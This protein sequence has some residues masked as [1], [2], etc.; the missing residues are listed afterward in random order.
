MRNTPAAEGVDF[1]KRRLCL[2]RRNDVVDQALHPGL[3]D[4]VRASRK[5]RAGRAHQHVTAPDE[6]QSSRDFTDLLYTPDGKQDRALDP[7]WLLA[8]VK[9]D[10]NRQLV[11]YCEK[12]WI[13][14]DDL[15]RFEQE[16]GRKLRPMLVPF[17][18]K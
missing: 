16:S 11:V 10:K 3:R 18:L 15:A 2:G 5:L 6:R 13:H 9:W 1:L 12:I 8:T 4:P 14:R 17:N 7:V